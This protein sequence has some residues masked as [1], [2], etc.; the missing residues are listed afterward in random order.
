M[1]QSIRSQLLRHIEQQ[2]PLS[3][4]T[5]PELYQYLGVPKYK[6]A[7]VRGALYGVCIG[8]TT[9]ARTRPPKL[10]GIRL[11]L[12]SGKEV[13]LSLPGLPREALSLDYGDGGEVDRI[14]QRLERRYGKTT[15]AFWVK[16][17]QRRSVEQSACA[18]R[19]AKKRD[20]R[21]CLLCRIEGKTEHRPV[22]AC[23]LVSRKSSFWKALDEVEKTKG[24]I[25][26]DEASLHLDKKLR[27]LTVHSDSRFIVTLCSEHD[28]LLLTTLAKAFFEESTD[29]KQISLYDTADV[30]TSQEVV[31]LK[32][33]ADGGSVTLLGWLSPNGQWSFRLATDESSL[34]N[35]LGEDPGGSSAPVRWS[36]GWKTGL[37]LLAKY[38]WQHLYPL[39]IH[40]EFAVPIM[41]EIEMSDLEP[42]DK[43]RW[44]EFIHDAA[45]KELYAKKRVL[46]DTAIKKADEWDREGL[47][48]VTKRRQPAG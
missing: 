2:P 3:T 17:T 30:N 45:E 22:R 20:S 13:V 39:E 40:P 47:L 24:A 25:F 7:A 33:G 46:L 19:T 43:V 32:V 5:F 44:R 12:L 34:W 31:I 6:E 11:E 16:A 48:P 9:T 36:S 21:S 29:E 28:K 41:T 18:M 42:S 37:K 35:L 8:T 1:K 38:P 23:H 27:D 15:I 4:I 10:Y 14:I 26:T